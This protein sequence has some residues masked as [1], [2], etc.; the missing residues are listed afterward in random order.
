MLK[1]KLQYFCYR[2]QRAD[3]LGKT[4]MLGKIAGRRRRGWQR[5]RWLDG[6]TGSMDMSL[7][8][9][10]EIVKDREAW[11]AA[12]H[13]I[14]KSRTWLSDWTTTNINM[15]RHWRLEDKF[16]QPYVCM[17]EPWENI[18]IYRNFFKFLFIFIFGCTGFHC[19]VQSFS[20]CSEWGLLL[21]CSVPASHCCG[22]SCHGAWALS[23]WAS[24][25]TAHRLSSCSRRALGHA[26][27][28][29]FGTRSH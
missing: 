27:F 4:L 5:M 11:R 20:G 14:A 15:S 6:I 24:V 12:V 23:A 7:S 28:S 1:Q 29:G 19:F 10:Q 21:Y 13:G 17:L 8:K 22:L 9:L 18:E 26:D 25:V 3:S 16:I 2:I